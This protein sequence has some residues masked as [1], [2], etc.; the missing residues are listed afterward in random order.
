MKRVPASAS[1]QSSLNIATAA[2]PDNIQPERFEDVV[3]DRDEQASAL[4]DFK[5][6]TR[7][8][9]CDL[10]FVREVKKALAEKT[11]IQEATIRELEVDK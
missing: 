10:S 3:C 9:G 2:P 6:W 5:K 11:K 4:N 1:I 8:A 7:I